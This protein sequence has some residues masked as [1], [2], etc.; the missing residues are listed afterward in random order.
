MKQHVKRNWLLA[1]CAV[2]LVTGGA[3]DVKVPAVYPLK[4]KEIY[5]KGWIDFRGVL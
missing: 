4:N 5:K 2:G 1:L 3:K